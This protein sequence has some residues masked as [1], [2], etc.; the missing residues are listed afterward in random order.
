MTIREVYQEYKHLDYL[1]SD[2]KWLPNN[3]IGYIVYE[4]WQAIKKE[5]EK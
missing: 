2:K 3:Q 4:L 5:K 1:L